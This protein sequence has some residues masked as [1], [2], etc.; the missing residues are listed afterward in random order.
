[1]FKTF[2]SSRLRLR[3]ININD[4][5]Y[6]FNNWAQELT[7][8]KYMTWIPH[9][10]IKQTKQFVAS[11]IKGWNRNDFTWVIEIKGSKEIIGSFA[12]RQD[13]HKLDIGYLLVEKHW[14]KGYM[15]EII[16]SFI[17]SAFKIK[18]IKRIWA[19][20]DV[21]NNASKRVMEK[22][23]MSYE[24]VLKSWLVHPNMKNNPRDCHCLGI[25]KN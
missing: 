22:S 7:I 10:N 3:P 5:D 18:G 21:E 23:G 6:L 4:A 2:E 15:T 11:C 14:G 9:D 16:T 25:I 24:G 19:V 8:A 12:A 17:K 1:M 13:A 20:C